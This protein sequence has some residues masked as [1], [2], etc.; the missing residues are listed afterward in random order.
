LF[1]VDQDP[2]PITKFATGAMETATNRAHRDLEN[3]ADLLVTTTIEVLEDD[4]SP[5]LG[6]Q[7]IKSGRDNPLALGSLERDRR[8]SLG[9]FV[10]RLGTMVSRLVALDSM[11]RADT[12]FSMSTQGKIDRDPVN[13][14]IKRTLPV[15]LVQL[16]ERPDECILQHILGIFG[17][18]QEPEYGRVQPILIPADQHPERLG[19]TRATLLHKAL[20]VKTPGHHNP[21]TCEIG[22]QFPEIR[23]S[24]G[25]RPRDFELA[26]HARFEP[27]TSYLHLILPVWR[28]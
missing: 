24:I 7:L 17:G 22:R 12:P 2:K 20:V 28:W 19:P 26:P 18:A 25:R 8:I 14:G 13:P 21:S 23:Q 27:E 9:R 11:R 15:E 3:L 10:G 4:D 5:V 16:L 1:F 6:P